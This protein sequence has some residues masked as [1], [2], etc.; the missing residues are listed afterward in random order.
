MRRELLSKQSSEIRTMFARIAGRYDLLNRLLS[1]GRDVAWRR[2][3]ARR[4][5]AHEPALVLDVCT[6][7]GDLALALAAPVVGADFCLP[8]LAL[9]RRK[10]GRR[11]R[12]LPLCAADALRLPFADA[13][14]DAVTVAFGVRNFEALDAG[15]RELVRVLRPGGA[16]LV[17]EFA[18][19]RGPLA[20]ALGWWVRTVP[21]RLGR[22]LSGDLE[23][24][25]YLPASVST[26]P[27][28]A[29]LCR[30]LEAAGLV[31]VGARPLTGGVAALY[32]GRRPPRETP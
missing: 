6:G 22:L 12:A 11:G 27:E 19:P 23:A 7:T 20:P 4:V 10:A 18:R 13:T 9:A 28:G 31:E 15:L 25:S 17:L 24:Y 5:A 2:V 1:L 14:V 3:V 16:L 32:E 8:M 26:F 21:P 30:S 29:A